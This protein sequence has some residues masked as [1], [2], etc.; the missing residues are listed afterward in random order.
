MSGGAD[1]TPAGQ[2]TPASRDVTLQPAGGTANFSSFETVAT[3]P[4]VND[5]YEIRTV[6]FADAGTQRSSG[7][8]VNVNAGVG[9]V[10]GGSH[11]GV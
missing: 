3:G 6:G 5:D 7:V 9:T 11:R 1:G 8:R 10:G 4:G 2:P